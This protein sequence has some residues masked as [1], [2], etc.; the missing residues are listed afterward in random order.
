MI[1]DIVYQRDTIVTV[2]TNVSCV[3]KR[4]AIDMANIKIKESLKTNGV[5]Q[6]QLADLMHVSESTI[7]KRLRHE[8]PEDEQ[9]RI[10]DLIRQ[11]AKKAEG[12]HE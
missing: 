3:N 11:A 5:Y 6:W 1:L 12:K 2:A 7:I 4:K 10:C 8:L 9:D